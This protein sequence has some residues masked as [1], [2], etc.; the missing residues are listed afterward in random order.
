MMHKIS[1]R[2][3]RPLLPALFATIVM[4]GSGVSQATLVGSMEGSFAVSSGA[5]TYSLP[6]KVSPG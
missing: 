5:A 2:I 4:A 3:S 1:A 6:M